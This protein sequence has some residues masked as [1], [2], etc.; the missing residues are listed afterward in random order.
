MLILSSFVQDKDGSEDECRWCGQGGDVLCCESCDKVFCTACIVRNLGEEGLEKISNT[1]DWKCFFCNKEPLNDLRQQ[2]K[3]VKEAMKAQMLQDSDV[4]F[5]NETEGKMR[6][7]NS[8]SVPT[9]FSK[10]FTGY[11]INLLT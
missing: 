11:L 4:E 5:V 8:G 7:K 3:L 1:E 10:L 9:L 6:R 2:Y